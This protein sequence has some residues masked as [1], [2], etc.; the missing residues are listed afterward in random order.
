MAKIRETPVAFSN[1]GAK[2]IQEELASRDLP[3]LL[4]STPGAYATEQGGGSG[5]ARVTI[6]GFDQRNVAV[7]VDGVPVNDMENGQVYWSNW[8]GLGD[9]T[10][11]VQV[12]RGLGASKLALASIGGTMN[13]ITKGIDSKKEISF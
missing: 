2:Q 11:N 12:Q 10:R 13:I 7:L 1:I 5:D 4:N 9:V 8:D 3:M 6:R